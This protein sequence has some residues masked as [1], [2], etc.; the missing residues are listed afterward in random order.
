MR[1]EA[2]CKLSFVPREPS[3]GS[4]TELAPKAG[5]RKRSPARAVVALVVLAAA[6][7]FVVQNRQ[8]VTV[9]LWFATGHVGLLWLVLVCV[10]LGGVAELAVARAIRVRWRSRRGRSS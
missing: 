8:A 9:R 4:E 2:A 3:K 1:A 5:R 6:V 7:T 10:V